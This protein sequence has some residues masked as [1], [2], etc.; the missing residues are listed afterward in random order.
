M[1]TKHNTS[2]TDG[3]LIVIEGIDGTGKSTQATMLAEALRKSGREVVQSFEPTNG[4][5]GKKLRESATTGRLSIEDELEYFINDRREH[6]EELIIPTIKSGGI[7]ILDRYYF[8]TMAYQG[9]RG[10]DP[11][12]IR[13]K[14]EIFAP[15]PDMLI[16]LDLDV[17]IALQRIG[18]RDGAANEFDKRE[19][20][21]FCRKLFLSLKDET[22]AHL[23]NANTNITEVNASVMAAVHT[24]LGM[25]PAS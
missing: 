7:V 9:A 16:I 19:S 13:A 24:Q 14:N 17:D 1:S 21:D 5:W 3:Y 25:E 10:I 20:L 4:P 12:A 22:Y 11:E 8:S 23:I 18:V 15:Q 2:G 6:V